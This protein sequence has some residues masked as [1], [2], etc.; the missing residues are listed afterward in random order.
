MGTSVISKIGSFFL[1]TFEK[2][3]HELVR[4]RHSCYWSLKHYSL[5]I[6]PERYQSKVS[7]QKVSL[8]LGSFSTVPETN[9]YNSKSF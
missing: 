3:G 8:P 4:V 2:W 9:Q 1:K 6:K 5:S 7:Q